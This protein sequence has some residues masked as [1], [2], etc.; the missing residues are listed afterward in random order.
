MEVMLMFF[1]QDIKDYI[2]KGNFGLEKESLRITQDGYISKTL[3]PFNNNENISRDFCENQVEIVTE[4]YSSIE[5]LYNGLKSIN[6]YVKNTLKNL[7]E[8]EYLW[9]FSNP[10]YFKGE[11]DI[12][13]AN[14]EDNLNHKQVYREYLAKKYGK[15]LMLYSGIHY[16]FSFNDD[17]FKYLYEHNS[18]TS[19]KDFVSDLYLDLAKKLSKYSWLLVALTSASPI[20]D[21]SFIN[22]NF[23]GVDG[24][25]GYASMRN[26]SHGYW[27]KFNLILDYSSLDNYIKSIQHYI[28]IGKIASVGECYVPIRLK[29][30]GENSLDTLKNGI[31]HIELRMFDLNPLD[32]VGIKIED[33]Y[34]THYLIIYLMSLPNEN[35]SEQNQVCAIENHKKASSFYLE[36]V[37][38]YVDGKEISLVKKANEILL[39]MI[40]FFSQFNSIIPIDII[41]FQRSKVLNPKNRY[42]NQIYDG[43]KNGFVKNGV[44]LSKRYSNERIEA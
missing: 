38:I 1:N 16:N 12:P 11:N 21:C 25:N 39:D 6:D 14:F 9:Y 22:D 36:D 15:R 27:N 30:K 33:L 35:F 32:N 17:F 2:F 34:F 5:K 3:H 18:I 28:D 13:I 26:S 24:F 42:S 8:P 44:K 7:K 19:Y 20:Y 10:P 31:N 4:V 37:N 29:P 43:Y 40:S 41:K 23:F